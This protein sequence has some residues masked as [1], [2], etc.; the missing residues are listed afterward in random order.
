MLSF[1]ALPPFPVSKCR[2]LPATNQC[3]QRRGK[4]RFPPP[5]GVEHSHSNGVGGVGAVLPNFPL[6]F[7]IAES[8]KS[9]R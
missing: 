5:S 9:C 3:C 8:A 4:M 1:D 6:S 7:T 2:R